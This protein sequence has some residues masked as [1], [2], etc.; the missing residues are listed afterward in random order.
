[1]ADFWSGIGVQHGRWGLTGFTEIQV[2][3]LAQG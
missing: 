3:N 1:M 2:V